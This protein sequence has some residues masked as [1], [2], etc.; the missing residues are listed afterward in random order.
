V[1]KVLLK[2]FVTGQTIRSGRAIA[3]LRRICEEDL[4]TEYELTIIDVL[5]RPQ[6]AEDEKILATP[7]LIRESPLPVRRII[8]DLSDTKQVLLGLDLHRQVPR[9]E[10]R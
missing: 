1:E 4:G 5:E 6:L 9:G 8:G 2:L 7:T 10:E 3:N